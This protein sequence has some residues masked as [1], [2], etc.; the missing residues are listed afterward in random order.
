MNDIISRNSVLPILYTPNPVPETEASEIEMLRWQKS[1]SEYIL[2]FGTFEYH[3]S[4]DR[5]V[6]SD[7]VYRLFDYDM[8]RPTLTY[9]WF[10]KQL[11]PGNKEEMLKQ[12]NAVVSGK[13]D[14]SIEL[15]ILTRKNRKKHIQ[16]V[17]RKIMDQ[18]GTVIR[19]LGI[20]RDI[21]VKYLQQKHL[22]E[23]IEELEYSNKEL[24]EFAYIASHDLQEPLR[25]IS[26]FTDRL[27]K[28][29]LSWE[30]RDARMYMNR[31]CASAQSMRVLI[32]SLLD[33]SR[34][35]RTSKPFVPTDLNVLLQQ[36]CN[37]LD[38]VIEETGTTI[39]A[40]VLPCLPVI[41]AQIKQ[42]FYNI[43]SN[44][45]KFRKADLPQRIE[46]T[47]EKLSEY[48]CLALQL[49]VNGDYH[50]IAF[51]D[52]GIGF[53]EIYA[54]TIFQIFQRLHGKSEYPGSGI[55]LAICKKIVDQHDGVIYA[56]GM[57]GE[58]AVFTV[59]LP[60]AR[61]TTS[62]NGNP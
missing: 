60:G 44:A 7:G 19:N 58:G 14:Y 36:A 39:E 48:E 6:A 31:I 23:V 25:K 20:V 11:L 47:T 10:L 45:I 1:E 13:E 59:L 50:K 62:E 21:T 8:E 53:D 52:A 28:C 56:E 26:I 18:S 9:K 55:G 35:S 37:D 34:I 16:I 41:P 15:D 38:L 51:R 17:G 30:D 32:D 12:L 5:A 49:P 61:I 57:P 24:E 22:K 4:E 29:L 40:P 27:N 46:I 3:L 42:L 2:Q 43:I 54:H 33:F